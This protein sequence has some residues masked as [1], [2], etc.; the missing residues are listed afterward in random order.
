MFSIF[1]LAE[2]HHEVKCQTELALISSPSDSGR[3]A[4]WNDAISFE[5][6]PEPHNDW[7]DSF[8]ARKQC[9]L[10]GMLEQSLSC[11]F[12]YCS[13]SFLIFLLC[14]VPIMLQIFLRAQGRVRFSSCHPHT[15]RFLAW[16]GLALLPLPPKNTYQKDEKTLL[17]CIVWTFRGKWI[18]QW[19]SFV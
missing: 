2:S 9:Y 7:C 1:N 3:Q 16:G 18:L 14:I 6:Y 11:S 12:S 8:Q 5:L 19:K 10:L 13:G 4:P 17:S 15:H